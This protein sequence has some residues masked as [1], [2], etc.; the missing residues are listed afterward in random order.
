MRVIHTFLHL[1]FRR[2]AAFLDSCSVDALKETKKL[3]QKSHEYVHRSLRDET[4]LSFATAN[5]VINAMRE[6]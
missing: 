5:R 4:G 6:V 2:V 3:L 1:D